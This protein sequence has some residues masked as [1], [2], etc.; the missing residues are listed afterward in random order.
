MKKL[1]AMLLA[2]VLCLSFA[3]CGASNAPASDSAAKE[4][5]PASATAAPEAPA[6]STAP[7]T[8]AAPDTAA[9]AASE[10]SAA[11]GTVNIPITD[12]PTTLQGWMLRNSNELVLASAIYE[13]LLMYDKTGKPQPYLVESFEGDAAALT[14]TM[15]VHEG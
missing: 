8:A 4:P 1:I 2:M 13:T 9:P 15:K 11:G 6:A 5:A 12:D 7:E 10:S 3:A 14:Y